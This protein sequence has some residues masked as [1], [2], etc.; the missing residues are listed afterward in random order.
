LI[1]AAVYLV[2]RMVPLEW[3][4]AESFLN[5]SGAASGSAMP[6][7]PFYVAI[8]HPS[9]ILIYFLGIVWVFTMLNLAHTFLYT[10]SRIILA[11]AED[12]LI[13]AS[14]VFVH[15]ELH[16]PL[17]TILMI[18]ILAEVGVVDTALQ[19][20]VTNTTDPVFFI[21]ATQLLPVL[22]ITLLPFL[23]RDWYRK[24]PSI[25]QWRIGPLPMITLVGVLALAYQI[26]MLSAL[27]VW[28]GFSQVGVGTAIT[29]AVVF[30]SGV[31]W[32][33]VRRHT[34]IQGGEDVDSWLKRLPEE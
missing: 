21:T 24:A 15:P 5:Q 4:S 17:I 3:L 9:A 34:L 18:C 8:L 27:I 25:L 7:L 29:F 10:G 11:W 6:W 1:G 14:A 19:N 26:W 30:L 23:R 2:Q 20:G 32:F 28:P 16:S 33:Y 12:H 31:A 13:P 22:G